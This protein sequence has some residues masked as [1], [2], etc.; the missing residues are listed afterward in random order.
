M[1]DERQKR[2]HF[3]SV[4]RT[5]LTVD[6]LNLSFRIEGFQRVEPFPFIITKKPLPEAV[7]GA[8]P[9]SAGAGDGIHQSFSKM[10]A[11]AGNTGNRLYFAEQIPHLRNLKLNDRFF[12]RKWHSGQGIEPR[13]PTSQKSQ[14]EA[15]RHA[16]AS[17]LR[18][19]IHT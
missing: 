10:P 4:N 5:F 19:V 2:K 8:R 1:A 14:P 18:I 9:N 13:E 15:T 17:H 7:A 12:P 16:K 3:L 6:R 11:K